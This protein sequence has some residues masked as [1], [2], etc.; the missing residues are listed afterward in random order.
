MKARWL[1]LTLGSLLVVAPAC[2]DKSKDDKKSQKDDDDD[3]DKPTKKKPRG[4]ASASASAGDAPTSTGG[5]AKVDLPPPPAGPTE[6]PKAPLSK[7]QLDAFLKDESQKLTADAYESLLIGLQA[8]DVDRYGIDYKC[9]AYKDYGTYSKHKNDDYKMIGKVSLKH[10]RDPKPAVRYQATSDASFYAFGF[11]ADPEAPTKFL[12]AAQAEQE[13]VVLAHMIAR[14]VSGAKKN[15]PLRTFVMSQVD[16]A[17]A[18]VREDAVRVI[19]EPENAVLIPNAFEKLLEKAQGDADDNV[20]ATACSVLASPGADKAIPVFQ[21]MLEDS[22]LKSDI[23]NGCFEGLV[24]SWVTIPY[25]KKPSKEGYELT[26]KLLETKP[27]SKEMP[28]WRG[29]SKISFAKTTFKD[30]D[31]SGKE[32]LEA[33]KGFYDKARVVKA[34][35]DLAVDDKANQIPRSDAIYVLRRLGEQK[36][37]GP[38]A[39]TIKKQSGYEAKSLSQSAEKYSKEKDD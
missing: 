8:C 4:S 32:W 30:Y 17:N 14:M 35:Q 12:Q 37:L 19:G 2:G 16:H 39:E 24:A 20:R 36:L 28:P 18:R 21:K 31:K 7:E 3:D 13:P 34:M 10:L 23:R 6:M 9:Q 1:L 11:D 26:M 38:I 22:S 25:P 15:E 27:R 5:G 33:V 29:I